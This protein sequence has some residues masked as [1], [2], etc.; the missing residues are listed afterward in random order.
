MLVL[1]FAVLVVLAVGGGA[2]I[3]VASIHLAA[4]RVL[5]GRKLDLEERTIAL[6]EQKAK[7]APTPTTIP[8]DLYRRIT[9]WG[10]PMAQE[11]ERKII[12]DLYAEV[13]SHYPDE[14]QRWVEVRRLLPRPPSDDD[15][16][17]LL[18]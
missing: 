6:S 13:A 9:A 5:R 7:G 1:G 2:V 10:D 14:P 18:S 15:G 11:S 12:L 8:P 3:R 4:D 17:V 16:E